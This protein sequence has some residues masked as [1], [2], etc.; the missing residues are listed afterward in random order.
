MSDNTVIQ[1]SHKISKTTQFLDN[2]AWRNCVETVGLAKIQ[3][4]I[5]LCPEQTVS[6]CC[7]KQA[8][9]ES[10]EYLKK[11]LPKPKRYQSLNS[12]PTCTFTLKTQVN[13]L[14]VSGSRPIMVVYPDDVWYRQATLE[15]I[16]RIAQTLDRHNGG[17]RICIFNPSFAR[18][19]SGCL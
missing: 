3:R 10:G 1:C 7:S 13:S 6:H 9:L 2:K 15:A 8:S 11:R 4:H 5:S 16:E 19:F 18:N 12:N 14:R 17:G